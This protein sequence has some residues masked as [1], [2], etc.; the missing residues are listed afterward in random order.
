MAGLL[1]L[2]KGSNGVY[3]QKSDNPYAFLDT[4]NPVQQKRDALL[5]LIIQNALEKPSWSSPIVAGI[6]SWMLTRG[7]GRQQQQIQAL[8]Q[9]RN[10]FL[11]GVKQIAS[12]ELPPDEKINQ[13][14]N[15]KLQYGTDFGLG[16]A[17]IIKIYQERAKR[18]AR[19]ERPQDLSALSKR[20]VGVAGEVTPPTEDITQQYAAY[21]LA[22]LAGGG[23]VLAPRGTTLNEGYM[24]SPEGKMIGSY[25]P[26]YEPKLD[27]SVVPA[28]VRQQLGVPKEG[29]ARKFTGLGERTK[30]KKLSL[31]E[32]WRADLRAF[33]ANKL[34]E[35]ELREKYSEPSKQKRIDEMIYLMSPK[36]EKNPKF[37]VGRGLSAW[38]SKNIAN[39]AD[40][41]TWD[42]I[43]SIQRDKD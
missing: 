20:L 30:E 31:T 18:A 25:L 2:I 42:V 14:V 1:D 22:D 16:L 36:I 8:R 26:G 33:K 38:R 11:N 24:Y 13:L 19:A 7:Q 3:R 23:K 5:S 32:Q 34:S 10:E 41:K 40:Q 35:A 21:N 17:D 39:I 6:G 15:W 12:S 4:V 27:T 43:N 37:R 28:M 29:A 9:K